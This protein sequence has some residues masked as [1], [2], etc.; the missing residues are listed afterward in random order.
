VR[1][2]D[3]TF[4]LTKAMTGSHHQKQDS[5]AIQESFVKSSEVSA[6]SSAWH[7]HMLEQVSDRGVQT[8]RTA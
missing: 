1:I 8:L 2:G 6:I 5:G 4:K 7:C 3:L